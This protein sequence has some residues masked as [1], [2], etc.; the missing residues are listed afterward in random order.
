MTP[1]GL[2]LIMLGFLSWTDKGHA[3]AGG[4]TYPIYALPDHALPDLYDGTLA[5][6]REIFPEP[7]LTD[8]DFGSLNIG[9]GVKLG[10]SDLTAKIYL[11]WNRTQNQIYGAIERKDNIYISAYENTT[12]GDTLWAY[13]SVEFMIDGDHSGGCYAGS[14]LGEGWGDPKRPVNFHAQQYVFV[15]QAPE[16]Q[17]MWY[18]GFST[19]LLQPP[20]TEAGGFVVEGMSHRSVV[21]F[22][23]TPFDK[24]YYDHSG[25]NV[26]SHLSEG[27]VIGF[28]VSLPD[29]DTTPRQYHGYHTLAGQPNTW[30]EADNFVDGLLI[31]TTP[32]TWIQVDSWARIKASFR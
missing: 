20:Y 11:G 32:T 24:L 5:D 22:M 23:V 9:E 17:L 25:E 21:E 29:F 12:Y 13:D 3:H 30:R 18:G 14:C 2:F 7:T 1:L 8:A 31:D 28:Q 27:K 6:W 26:K 10:A 4:L 16:D 15:A 19:W